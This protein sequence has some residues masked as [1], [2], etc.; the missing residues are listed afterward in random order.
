MTALK[1]HDELQFTYSYHHI[2]R[3][4]TPRR[5]TWS[6]CRRGDYY[7]NVRLTVHWCLFYF[8]SAAPL[9][10][11]AGDFIFTLTGLE[12]DQVTETNITKYDYE[13]TKKQQM[14]SRPQD[15]WCAR[16]LASQWN[17]G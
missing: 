2:G 12:P 6:G 7:W 11:R 10:K 13:G 17:E 8:S 15:G 1:Q 9:V 4:W 14:H 3:Q 5:I 16:T